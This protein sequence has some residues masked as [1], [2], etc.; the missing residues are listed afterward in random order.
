MRQPKSAQRR[1]ISIVRL[2]DPDPFAAVDADAAVHMPRTTDLVGLARLGAE[3]EVERQ[4]SAIPSKPILCADVALE[5]GLLRCIAFR[6][7]GGMVV[8]PRAVELRAVRVAKLAF[9]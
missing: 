2:L 4:G 8:A 6:L 5:D 3:L 9:D 7:A 1:P